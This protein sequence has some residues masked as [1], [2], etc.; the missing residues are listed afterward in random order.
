[1]RDVHQG[2]E[3]GLQKLA[4][5]L[6][7]VGCVPIEKDYGLADIGRQPALE[8]AQEVDEVALVGHGIELEDGLLKALAY[9]TYHGH[10]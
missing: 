6:R 8:Y 4:Y 10:S 2:Y 5:C 7:L 3:V 1:M 9:G